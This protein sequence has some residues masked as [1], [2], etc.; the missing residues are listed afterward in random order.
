LGT[1]Q[2][3][4]L[5]AEAGEAATM[6]GAADGSNGAPTPASRMDG[7]AF[8][9]DPIP[10]VMDGGAQTWSLHGRSSCLGSFS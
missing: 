6:D 2:L 7:G 4:G 8:H 9:I 5:L 10:V 3:A 1:N